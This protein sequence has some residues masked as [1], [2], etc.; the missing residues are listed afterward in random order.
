[1][2]DLCY[3]DRTCIVFFQELLNGTESE[4]AETRSTKDLLNETVASLLAELSEQQV[5]TQL[6]NS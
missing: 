3:Q 5:S 4:L 1:M 6:W 2:N